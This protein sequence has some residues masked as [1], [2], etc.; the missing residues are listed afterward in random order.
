[1]SCKPIDVTFEKKESFD[2]VFCAEREHLDARFKDIGV[3]G[4][5]AYEIA[6]MRGFKGTVDEWL[7]SLHG[8]AGQP[9]RDGKDGQPGKDGQD[10]KPFTYDDFTAEQLE[11]LRGPAGKDGKDGEPGKD[12][13]DGQD[14]LP[15]KDG[16]PGRDGLDG[17]PGKDGKD[18]QPGEPG[19]DGQPGKDGAPGQP[20][21]D[22]YTPVRG[23]DYWTAEDKQEIV[24]DVLDQMPE[25]GAGGGA[26]IIDVIELP[27][28]N[29]DEDV[30]Y[31]LL[32]GTFVFNQY[33]Q[34][35]MICHCVDVLPETGEPVVSG[36][37][38]NLDNATTTAYYNTQDGT[39]SAYVTDMLSGI[40]GVPA[41]WY[42]AAVLMDAVG[43][44]FNG[45]IT[46]I[47]N[48]PMD[49]T[50]RLLLEYVVYTYKDGW[51]SLK[52]VGKAGTGASAEVFNHPSNRATGDA[53]HAE[54][55]ASHAE[56]YASH[57]E[58][59][60]SHAEGVYSHAEGYYSHA[61]G[62]YTHA[63]GCSQHVQGEYNVA[64]PEYDVNDPNKRGKYAHIV[65]NGT[66]ED[67]RSNAHT[68]DWEGNAWFAGGIELTSPN[69]TRF[70]F[71]VSDDGALTG[72]V[73]T[74]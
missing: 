17:A 8:K 72:T 1:M 59:D 5:S 19:K 14:G 34:N 36:D 67:H 31:R 45:V 56:G 43:Y 68:L 10:G 50:F 21:A 23:K 52:P 49:N 11:S 7:E 47:L 57:A 39:V 58:G 70:R 25:G 20:G 12:G 65:G 27:T 28:E 53:S 33:T 66:F 35:N 44:T 2:A 29:I 18:G 13:K 55:D 48:D 26:A 22:G 30:F 60:A 15:G 16:A 51:H 32:T 62:Y 64:D 4:Q 69:G 74:E 61:E 38:S 71:T 63:A 37:L 42:P 46:D 73:V 24:E 54:G 40:F 9:G 3:K 41:G 6:V